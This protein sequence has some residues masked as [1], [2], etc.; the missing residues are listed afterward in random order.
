MTAKNKVYLS[1]LGIA[2]I[3][4]LFYLILYL[5]IPGFYPPNAAKKGED[6]LNIPLSPLATSSPATST[7]EVYTNKRGDKWTLDDNAKFSVSSANGAKIKF[8]EGQITPLKVHPGDTQKMRIVV[9]G[10]NGITGVKAEIETDNGTTTVALKKTGVL[11]VRDLDFR[12][13]QYQVNDSNQLVVLSPLNALTSRE[14]EIAKETRSETISSAAAASGEREVYEASWLVKDTS[15]R[16]YITIFTATDS[17]GNKEKITL[18]WSD[19]CRT[20]AGGTSYWPLNGGGAT[21]TDM[22]EA[23]SIASVYGIDNGNLSLKDGSDITISSGGQ[24]VFNP[25]RFITIQPNTNAHIY[26]TGSGS[27]AASYLWAVDGDGDHYAPNDTRLAYSDPSNPPNVGY[28]RQMSL[29]ASTTDCYDSN[30]NAKPGQT[31]Y[32]LTQ[33]GDGSFDYDCNGALGYSTSTSA[34]SAVHYTCLGTET[35]CN[36]VS[37]K[38]LYI[39]DAE[40]SLEKV[41][42]F[43]GAG[44]CFDTPGGNPPAAFPAC[45][46][47]HVGGTYFSGESCVFF[48]GIEDFKRGDI[49]PSYFYEDVYCK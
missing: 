49:T 40:L 29:A 39:Y 30:A 18:A 36:D 1:A 33:R 37:G 26:L 42:Q 38:R 46:S 15:V 35:Y 23:C 44:S 24:L 47:I 28:V 17:Q 4:T 19:P 16:D 5:I 43:G 41:N 27:M 31:A 34:T 14:Q 8:L 12:L 2:L 48:D 11:A 9:Q 7:K 6:I 13:F 22:G 32:F 45:G 25:D 21:T 3:L 10:V 20:S